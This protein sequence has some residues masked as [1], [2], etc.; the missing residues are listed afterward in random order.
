M[1]VP[2]MDFSADCVKP[3]KYCWRD[4]ELLTNS[5][6][7]ENFIGTINFGKVYRGKTQQGQEVTVKIWLY[8]DV[9]RI[10]KYDA[11]YGLTRLESECIFLT[12]PDVVNHPNLVKLI[13]YCCEV[14]DHHFG[15]VYDLRSKDTLI[16]LTD[17]DDLTWKQRMQ[18]ASAIA[19]VLAHLHCQNPPYS[20]H[21][22][23]PALI[24]LD[25]DFNP[26]LF[27]FFML[28]GGVLG[29]KQHLLNQEVMLIADIPYLDNSFFKTGDWG[30]RADQFSFAIV[31]LELICKH[32]F[33]GEK[34][35]YDD[36]LPELWAWTKYKH[37]GF[38][39]VDCPLVHESLKREPGFHVFD[40]VAITKL[41][42][43]CVVY[44]EIRPTMSQIVQFMEGLHF[45]TGGFGGTVLKGLL[46]KWDADDVFSSSVKRERGCFHFPCLVRKKR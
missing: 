35:K 46:D 27:D 16:N 17:K 2:E 3:K 9:G 37:S 23:H 11:N 20:L 41:I 45:F 13:G 32:A 4:L 22:V 19:R 36:E 34:W 29:E 25:Q 30:P 40:G 42:F 21:F 8:P 38:Q 24:M 28:T 6:S 43:R 31:L 14:E 39:P 18:V 7:E 10:A 1:P 12:H 26:V 44:H 5:F 15:V 33:G